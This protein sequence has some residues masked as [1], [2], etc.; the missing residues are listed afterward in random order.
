[1]QSTT[2]R[3]SILQQHYFLVMTDVKYD[4]QLLVLCRGADLWSSCTVAYSSCKTQIA[5]MVDLKCCNGGL[6]VL[7]W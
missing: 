4:R 3:S 6:K 5:V 2:C 1:M 7:L